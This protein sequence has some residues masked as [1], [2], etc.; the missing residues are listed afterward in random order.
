MDFE[1][2]YNFEPQKTK[3]FFFCNKKV[4]DFQNFNYPSCLVA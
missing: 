4:K 2:I 3:I 1:V